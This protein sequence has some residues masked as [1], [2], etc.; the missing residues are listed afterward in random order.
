ML[1]LWTL[2]PMELADKIL[3][4]A[5]PDSLHLHIVDLRPHLVTAPRGPDNSNPSLNRGS[6]E[7][8]E[9]TDSVAEWKEMITVTSVSK[10]TRQRALLVLKENTR[11]NLTMTPFASLGQTQFN[12]GFTNWFGMCK[13]VVLKEYRYISLSDI[14]RPWIAGTPES[15]GEIYVSIQT[16]LFLDDGDISTRPKVTWHL[17]TRP[18]KS[19]ELCILKEFMSSFQTVASTFYCDRS[20]GFQADLLGAQGDRDTVLMERAWSL[21]NSS[22]SVFHVPGA[23]K[24]TLCHGFQYHGCSV[25]ESWEETDVDQVREW[26]KDCVREKLRRVAGEAFFVPMQG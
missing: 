15:A 22:I 19:Q 11:V 5:V 10:G 1:S 25:G 16:R 7:R 9:W 6:L 14:F 12:L 4:E 21:V 13:E 26:E 23:K 24:S 2:I 20:G 18:K 3:G 17:E 8:E